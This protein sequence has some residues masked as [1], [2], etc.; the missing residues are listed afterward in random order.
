MGNVPVIHEAFQQTCYDRHITVKIVISF[1]KCFYFFFLRK[2]GP[3]LTSVPIFLYFTCGPPTTAWLAM[4]CHVCTGIRTSE[5]WATEVERAHLTAAP[6]GW[7]LLGIFEQ[8]IAS[9]LWC[10]PQ[11]LHGF[12]TSVTC[13]K[14]ALPSPAFLPTRAHWLELISYTLMHCL[15]F[16]FL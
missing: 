7:P 8:Q 3:E 10:M 12:V 4:W 16:W 5:P 14:N 15:Q 6:P 11:E 9:L 2:T 13:C 1:F